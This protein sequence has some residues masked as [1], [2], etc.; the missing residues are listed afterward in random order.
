MKKHII[1]LRVTG[2]ER[3]HP[4][5]VLVKGTPVD[6]SPL[7]EMLPGQFA[8]LKVDSSPETYLRR[9]ISIHDLTTD[10]TD[11]S[12]GEVSFL[13]ALAGAGT[14]K[15]STLNVGDTLNV[16]IPLGNGF[17]MPTAEAPHILLVGGGVGIAPL[18]LMG[19][20]MKDAGFTPTFLLGGRSAGDILRLSEYEALGPVHVT[21]EDG[22]LGE[23]GFVTQHSLWQTA[24]FNRI[25]VCGPMPMMKAVAR[26]A[27]EKAIDCEVSLEN[28]MACGIGACLCCVEDTKE[29][30]HVCVCKEGPV[31]NINELKWQI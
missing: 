22:T 4:R 7:P 16:I 1:D 6:G 21:T 3:L 2:V 31:F 18:L 29:K 11:V 30:G 15:L 25:A 27:K 9:P 13:I 23:K 14:K 12:R 17:T 28:M 26:L 10:M 8:Q 20:R 5:Y 19:R 24:N